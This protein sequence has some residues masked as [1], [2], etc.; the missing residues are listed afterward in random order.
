VDNYKLLING[1]KPLIGETFV[2]GGKNT[3]VAVIPAALLSDD[4]CTIE[5]VPDIEDVRVLYDILTMLGAKVDFDRQNRR[6]VI[7]PRQVNGTKVDHRYA[8]RMRASYYL[9]GALLGR[10]G[11][12]EVAYPGGCAIGSR[13]FD[14]HIKGFQALGAQVEDRA[15]VITAKG[16]LV[17]G[18]GC[19]LLTMCIR[20]GGGYP[21]GVSFAILIM[22]AL[23]PLINRYTQPKP[24]GRK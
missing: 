1:G 20:C 7:D 19:G 5:N 17:F 8:S 14:L 11:E 13:P 10:F 18:A 2:S 12:A 21:E 24:F 16:K 4:V 3:S 22:N 9:I 23:T 15:A 6:M